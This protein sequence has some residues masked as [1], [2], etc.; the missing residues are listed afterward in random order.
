M[1]MG[2]SAGL[3]NNRP[4]YSISVF[5]P[6]VCNGPH[7]RILRR[8]HLRFFVYPD[9]LFAGEQVIEKGKVHQLRSGVWLSL[10]TATTVLSVFR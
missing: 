2:V 4:A 7:C 6:A 10:A 8:H 9:R 1:A 3:R 5:T